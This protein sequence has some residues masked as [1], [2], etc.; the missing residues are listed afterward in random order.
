MKAVNVSPNLSV[1]ESVTADYSNIRIYNVTDLNI[2]IMD[3]YLSIWI[4]GH[5]KEVF[6]TM[7]GGQIS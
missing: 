7:A 2:W 4:T 5:F 1:I 3:I 6:I